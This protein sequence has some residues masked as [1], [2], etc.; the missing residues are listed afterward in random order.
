MDVCFPIWKENIDK[1]LDSISILD[2]INNII[3][4]PMEYN[5]EQLPFFDILVNKSQEPNNN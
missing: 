1:C 4:Y 3:H 2:D 5:K